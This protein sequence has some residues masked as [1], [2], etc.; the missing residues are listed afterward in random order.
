MTPS[1]R[2]AARRRAPKSPP[3]RGCA[4]PRRRSRSR[5]CLNQP[6]AVAVTP[7]FQPLGE[8]TRAVTVVP[9]NFYQIAS[10]AAE[11]E[12]MARVRIGFQ[13]F[14]HEQGEARKTAPH[15][16]MTSRQPH[17]NPRWNRYHRSASSAA[18][19]RASACGSTSLA[20][21]TV[22]PSASRI[23]IGVEDGGTVRAQAGGV[24]KGA[25]RAIGT[26]VG[27]PARNGAGSGRG[28]AKSRR[29]R[30]RRLV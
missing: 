11:D 15:I 14:L 1:A 30:N 29:Q 17:T 13:R 22:R 4:R 2:H 16:R 21:R 12:Q 19:I 20:V 24:G 3:G 10:L 25:V 27:A 9:D 8:Q 26:N 6:V 5:L 18:T 7:S 28:A 23:S